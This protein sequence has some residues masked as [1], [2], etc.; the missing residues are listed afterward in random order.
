MR[1]DDSSFFSPTAEVKATPFALFAKGGQAGERTRAGIFAVF[2]NRDREGDRVQP[3]AF[4]KTWAEG[5]KNIVH[6]WDHGQS[7][8]T[9]PTAS[10]DDLYEIAKSDLPDEVLEFAP[11]ATGGA[12]VVRTYVKSQLGDHLIA[13]VDSGA[14]KQMSFAY[15]IPLGKDEVIREQY[16]GETVSTRIIR[17]VRQYDT[18]DVRWGA[19]GA[20]IAELKSILGRKTTLEQLFE[21]L[22]AGA[23]NSAGDAAL[24]QQIHDL[25]KQLHPQCCSAADPDDPDEGI[26]LALELAKARLQMF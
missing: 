20:T 17:E 26:K 6:L 21:E 24:I 18:S 5:K 10:V 3:G 16:K 23:R 7:D 11:D 13:A 14:I 9:L 4:T 15:T 2:G 22:K 19:N 25:C 8:I 12:V 1:V